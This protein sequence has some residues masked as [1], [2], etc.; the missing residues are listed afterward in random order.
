MVTKVKNEIALV[1][2]Q[3]RQARAYLEG[4]VN[5]A[6]SLRDRLERLRGWRNPFP[7]HVRA[8]ICNLRFQTTLADSIFFACQICSL[9]HPT[10]IAVA[11]QKS[12]DN[13][14]LSARKGL[15]SL[16]QQDRLVNRM[17]RTI[18]SLKG[19]IEVIKKVIFTHQ[20]QQSSDCF[21]TDASSWPPVCYDQFR[22]R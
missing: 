17:Q 6:E 22:K 20:M 12:V 9:T 19:Q 21:S 7:T 18:E 4:R 3:L 5:T 1:K 2:S 13:K 10:T 8:V 14:F 11:D 16:G 15:A